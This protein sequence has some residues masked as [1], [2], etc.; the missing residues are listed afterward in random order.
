[1]PGTTPGRRDRDVARAEA[2]PPRVVER[3]DGGQHAV[4]VEQRLAHAHEHDVRQALAV[5][6][7]PAGGVADLV[8]D[9]GGL[10]VAP[11]PEL[12]GGAERAADRAAGLARDAQRVPLARAGRGPGSASGRDSISAPSA[13][14]W[15][16]FSVRPPSA[17]VGARC[18]RPCRSGSRASSAVAERRRQRP[19]L[20]GSVDAAVRP[21]RVGDLAGAKAGSPRSATQAASSSGVERR[22][23]PGRSV[24]SSRVDASAGRSRAR[25]IGAA[26]DRRPAAQRTPPTVIAPAAG[27][28]DLDRAAA[29][30]AV[31]DAEAAH[32][33]TMPRRPVRRRP[34]TRAAQTTRRPDRRVD[35]RAR[36]RLVGADLA[37][38]LDRRPPGSSRPSSRR[39]GR[40]SVAPS[41]GCG[42]GV[43]LAARAT[44]RAL[45]SSSA[46]GRD[47]ERAP[48]G[49][50]PSRRR[51]APTRRLGDDR[52]GVEARRPSASGSRR[53]RR[54]RRGSRPG[55]G[56]RRDAA[57]AATGAG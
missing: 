57:A 21:D 16:A 5:R 15:S 52:P 55:S 44:A 35:E 27:R 26:D 19:D 42:P 24:A 32:R 49:R 4:E 45:R 3:L 47:R 9:L 51:R 10:E 23:R 20:V 50:A 28:L 36:P 22:T 2:E 1:M 31:A 29:A 48:R 8:D 39:S 18:R 46:G 54:R 7:E 56:S 30:S 40:V 6:G 53:S 34:P 41:S 25:T 14:R 33:R 17:D 13:S 11:E 12:A 38:E 43:E 37:L